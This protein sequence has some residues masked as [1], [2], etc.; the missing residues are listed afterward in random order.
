[1]S[2]R[3]GHAAIAPS[4]GPVRKTA[5]DRGF[6]PHH[7]RKATMNTTG[8]NQKANG[9]MPKQ[10]QC[11]CWSCQLR[12]SFEAKHGVRERL[13]GNILDGLGD[14][15][16]INI[17]IPAGATPADVANLIASH[18]AKSDIM[19]TMREQAKKPA[20]AAPQPAAA[21]VK[22]TVEETT[23]GDARGDMGLPPV[24]ATA[25]ELIFKLSADLHEEADTTR[26]EA[27]SLAVLGNE[28][29][30]LTDEAQRGVRNLYR[31]ATG[32]SC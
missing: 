30:K 31:M 32:H 3:N 1:M 22:T 11:D 5:K 8:T 7:L 20:A 27:V 28:M 17:P 10:E 14:A 19:R 15:R 24:E 21:E 6:E 26:N 9:A 4:G 13:L 23:L 16:V 12:R 25:R 18:F 2:L 29:P